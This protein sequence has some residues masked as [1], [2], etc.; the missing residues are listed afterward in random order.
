MSQ[1]R[2]E[3]RELFGGDVVDIALGPP[4]GNII[5]MALANELGEE[6]RRLHVSPAGK[7]PKAIIISGTGKHFSFGASVEEHRAD[8]VGDMLPR[9]HALIKD[10]LALDIPTIAKV[11]GVCLGGG[12]ELALA[13]SMI[14]ADD[15]AKFAVPEIQLGVFPPVASVLLP[16]KISEAVACD[17]IFTGRQLGASDLLTLGLVN[18]MAAAGA[19]DATVEDFVTKHVLPKSASSLQMAYQVTRK[20]IVEH[21]VRHIGEAERI[22]LQQLM[23]TAD[24]VEGIE[25]FLAKRAPEWKNA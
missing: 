14:I 12:F 11:S 7:A 15:T 2:I 8:I 23:S 9:F 19:L 20:G 24:A 1:A 3:K 16:Y 22:Y 21:Y 4:P 10:V 25:A 17:M 6:L 18:R 5:T 13:C